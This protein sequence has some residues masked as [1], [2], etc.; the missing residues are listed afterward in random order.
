MIPTYPVLLLVIGDQDDR[1]LTRTGLIQ[2]LFP[3]QVVTERITLVLIRVARRDL[4][5]NPPLRFLTGRV[6]LI[7]RHWAADPAV[8]KGLQAGEYLVGVAAVEMDVV[9]FLCAG[10]LG[11]DLCVRSANHLLQLL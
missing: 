11:C 4:V 9:G 1:E 10:H 2:E 7:W 5:I 6:K 3:D 8:E